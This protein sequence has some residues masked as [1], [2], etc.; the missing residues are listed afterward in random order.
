[1][2]MCQQCSSGATSLMTIDI[3]YCGVNFFYRFVAEMHVQVTLKVELYAELK[4]KIRACFCEW[5]RWS[6]WTRGL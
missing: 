3:R 6:E 5:F 1:M 2:H 4:R